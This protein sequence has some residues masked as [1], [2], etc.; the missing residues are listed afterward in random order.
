M[1]LQLPKGIHFPNIGHITHVIIHKWYHLYAPSHFLPNMK[2]L[3]SVTFNHRVFQVNF[4]YNLLL[5]WLPWS[6]NALYD[7]IYLIQNFNL[8]FLLENLQ[9]CEAKKS[10]TRWKQH[11][12]LIEEMHNDSFNKKIVRKAQF[13]LN[14]QI[15]LDGPNNHQI[16]RIIK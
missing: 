12:S 10:K 14:V 1:W 11:F 7:W 16:I 2:I 4:I 15:C 9:V 8:S 3:L 5:R 6:N 13:C